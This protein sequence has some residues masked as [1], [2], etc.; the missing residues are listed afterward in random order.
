MIKAFKVLVLVGVLSTG[1][2]GCVGNTS[3]VK[4][5][6]DYAKFS[7]QQMP[8]SNDLSEEDEYQ[9]ALDLARFQVKHQKYRE[10]EVLLQRLRKVKSQEI[11]IY[12]LL[13]KSYEGQQQSETALVA[14]KQAVKLPNASVDDEAELARLAIMLSEYALAESVYQGWL[15]SKNISTR[16]SGLNNLGFSALL[17]KDVSL[18]RSYFQSALQEDPLNS[19]AMNN[20][21]LIKGFEEE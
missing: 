16:V 11:D 8:L 12:R 6:I 18:A 15:K 2:I 9:F 1:L 14:W 19:K 7:Q 10:A 13:A 21:K 20:L 17:Q 5:Q 3:K 4:S